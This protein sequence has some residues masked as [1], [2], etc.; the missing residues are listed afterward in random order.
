M[1]TRSLNLPILAANHAKTTSPNQKWAPKKKRAFKNLDGIP[2]VD[3]PVT[4]S[5]TAKRDRKV[6][7]TEGER[8]RDH[9]E[10]RTS[11]LDKRPFKSNQDDI[12]D[13][14]LTEDFEGSTLVEEVKVKKGDGSHKDPHKKSWRGSAW[15]AA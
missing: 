13:E 10:L 11:H 1:S 8:P 6:A 2:E 3:T 5:P 9:A 14:T 15:Y 4:S 7:Q 12:G